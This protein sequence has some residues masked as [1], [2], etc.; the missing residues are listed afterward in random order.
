MIVSVKSTLGASPSVHMKPRWPPEPVNAQSCSSEEER[1]VTTLITAAKETINHD[2]LPKKRGT[3]NG[4][5]RLVYVT[6]SPHAVGVLF[7]C[8]LWRQK[9]NRRI[10]S[11]SKWCLLRLKRR[12]PV[13]ISYH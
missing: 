12:K 1:C 9:W 6:R 5:I 10:K 8:C 2:D 3:V 13:L 4:L 7:P 11:A